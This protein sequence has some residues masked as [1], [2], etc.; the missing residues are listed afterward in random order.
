MERKIL[1]RFRQF[2]FVNVEGLGAMPRQKFLS[3]GFLLGG[4]DAHPD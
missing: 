3:F 4:M 2:N 1:R